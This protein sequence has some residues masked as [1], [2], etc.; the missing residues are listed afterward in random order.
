[1]RIIAGEY[2]SRVLATPPDGTVTRP[3]PDRVRESVFSLLRGHCEGAMVFDGFAGTGSIGLEC[4]SRGA[5]RVVCVERDRGMADL[6]RANVASLGCGDRVRVVVGDALGP[7]ALGQAPRPLTLAFIDPPYP[8][9]EDPVQFRRLMAQLSALVDLLTPE[10]FVVLRTPWPLR[11]PAGP[12]APA[13][14]QAETPRRKGR[15]DDWRREVRD[16]LDGRAPRRSAPSE[17]DAEPVPSDP[18]PAAGQVEPSLT[19]S[20]ADG[21]ETHV[22]RGTAV[23]LYAR[24]RAGAGA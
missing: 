22:Y 14:H 18:M 23:H 5:A 24:R 1:M 7:G 2:R 12:A 21:P 15:R 19:L 13:P 3:M 17:P 20:N 4:A 16:A 10:G 11:H 8:L 9:A 6:I